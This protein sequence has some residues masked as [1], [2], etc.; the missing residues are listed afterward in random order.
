ME[1]GGRLRRGYG[2]YIQ[3]RDERHPGVLGP[4]SLLRGRTAFLF[5]GSVA[6]CLRREAALKGGQRVLTGWWCCSV[7]HSSRVQVY[8]TPWT[9]AHQAFHHHLPEFAQTHVLWVGDAI[10]PSQ[11]LSLPSPPAFNLS[12]HQGLFKWV[13]SLHQVAKVLELQL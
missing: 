9:A 2:K 5:L 13:N 6:G 11:P 7:S 10:Q 3:R 4:I 12:Q 8:A 1:E